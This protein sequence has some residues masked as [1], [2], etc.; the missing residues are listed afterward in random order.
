MC[1]YIFT[2]YG[3]IK[4]KIRKIYVLCNVKLLHIYQTTRRQVLFDFNLNLYYAV[5]VI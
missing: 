4:A 3:V 5:S 1:F 2:R